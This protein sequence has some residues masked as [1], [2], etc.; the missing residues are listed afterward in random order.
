MTSFNGPMI[1][2][3]VVEVEVVSEEEVVVEAMAV[4][5]VEPY[6]IAGF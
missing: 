5:L 4:S 2:L 3:P 6:G 1:L